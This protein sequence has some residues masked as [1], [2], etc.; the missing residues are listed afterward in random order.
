MYFTTLESALAMD[1]H[2]AFVWSAYGVTLVVVIYL[3]LAPGRR[4]RNILRNLRSEIQRSE[5]QRSE[6]QR[7]KQYADTSGTETS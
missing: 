7:Q 6:T 2:G 5:I 3:L 4:Q 1:G